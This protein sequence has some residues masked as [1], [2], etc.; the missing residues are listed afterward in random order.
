[1]V[2]IVTATII[3]LAAFLAFLIQRAR[4]LREIE[5]DLEVEWLGNLRISQMS[6]TLDKPWSLYIDVQLENKSRNHAH[7][8]R[9]KVELTV[10]PVRG[11]SQAIPS[12]FYQ[13]PRLHEDELMA[14]RTMVI[15]VYIGWNYALDLTKTVQSLPNHVIVE[16]AGFHALVIIEYSTRRELILFLLVPW[17]FGRLKYRRK[18]SRKGWGFIVDNSLSPPF[19]ERSWTFPEQSLHGLL[20]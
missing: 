13:F 5:P 3:G 15:P 1:M 18:T 11:R 6:K 19:A 20:S 12:K 7:D 17:S 2:A 8:L 4:Y 10:F 9:C 14:E 16:N